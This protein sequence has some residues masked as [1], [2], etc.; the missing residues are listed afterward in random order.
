MSN[1]KRSARAEIQSRAS[2]GSRREAGQK[3]KQKKPSQSVFAFRA[4]GGAREGA[5]RKRTSGRPQV[6]HVAR[7]Q[8]TARFPVLVTSRLLPG[9]PSMRRSEEARRVVTAIAGSLLAAE[10]ALERGTR[11]RTAGGQRMTAGR[12]RRPAG[13]QRRTAGTQRGSDSPGPAFQVV[14]YSI[15]SNHLHLIVEAQDRRTLSSGLRGLLIRI[16]FA[17]NKLWNRHGSVFAGRFHER[18]LLDPRQV[19]HALVYVLNNSRK[20]GVRHAGPD[21]LSSGP[22]FDGWITDEDERIEEQRLEEQRLEE[23]RIEEQRPGKRRPGAATGAAGSRGRILAGAPSRATRFGGS[24][25]RGGHSQPLAGLD[26][27]A[28]AGFPRA[29]TWLLSQGWKRHGLIDLLEAPRNS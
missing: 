12:R 14:H 22:G 5:G 16:A 2:S 26:R 27:A 29:S 18:E 15:Q 3:K 25:P 8:H 21:P 1:K 7:P 20:H 28:R 4:W 17:L 13:K 11:R 6:P 23:Q 10:D 9:L 19:R 24:A